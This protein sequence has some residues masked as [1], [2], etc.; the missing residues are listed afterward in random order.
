MVILVNGNIII[1]GNE[2]RLKSRRA[3][4]TRWCVSVVDDAVSI[5]TMYTR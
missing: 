5:C 2:Y 1:F 4:C 3:V